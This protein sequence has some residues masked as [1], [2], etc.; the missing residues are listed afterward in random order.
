MIS[1]FHGFKPHIEL[2]ADSADTAWDFL[3]PFLSSPPCSCCLCLSQKYIDKLKKLIRK[4]RSTNV[5]CSCRVL[6]RVPHSN[7][8][9]VMRTSRIYIFLSFVTASGTCALYAGP[10]PDNDGHL[11]LLDQEDAENRDI[12]R[13]S[14]LTPGSGSHCFTVLK[15]LPTS[16]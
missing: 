16:P 1:Q 5:N 2:C 11:L 4:E 9:A 6:S 12:H 15:D 8:R 10:Y 7:L 14:F 13:D 3:S